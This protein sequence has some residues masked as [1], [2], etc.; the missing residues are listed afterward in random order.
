MIHGQGNVLVAFDPQGLVFAVARNNTKIFLYDC[1]DYNGGPFY[2]WDVEDPQVYPGGLP[3]WT[4]IKFTSNGQYLLITTVADIIYVLDS[5]SGTITQ[6]LVG[7]A[8]PNKASCGEEVCTTPDA[9]YVIAGGRD[10]YLRIWDLSQ[11]EVMD[12]QPF[13]TLPTPHKNGVTVAGFNPVNAVGVTGGEELV[14]Y[15]PNINLHWI[16]SFDLLGF[17]VI[18]TLRRIPSS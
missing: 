10:S 11:K 15:M 17:L 3:A 6:R 8:G 7:H 13:V 12:N 18:T 14:S 5:F 4:S 1:R 16:N 9:K 2:T